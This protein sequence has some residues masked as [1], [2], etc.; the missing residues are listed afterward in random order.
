MGY[1]EV[2]GNGSVEWAIEVEDPKWVHSQSKVPKGHRQGGADQG[3]APG[4]MFT[5]RIEVPAGSARDALANALQKAAD[6][7]RQPGIAK[8]EFY[9]PIEKQNRDQIQILWP[10]A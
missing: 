2:G 3:G 9:L 1:G 10:D 4:Q 8:V 6:D 5:I 7:A